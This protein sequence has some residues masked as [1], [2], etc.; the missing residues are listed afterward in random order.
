MPPRVNLSPNISFALQVVRS[1][2]VAKSFVFAVIEVALRDFIEIETLRFHP[3]VFQFINLVAHEFDGCNKIGIILNKFL[4]G[5]L[6][7]VHFSWNT[8]QLL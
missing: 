4:W 3:I 2:F 1:F 6:H 5:V 7:A 8:F